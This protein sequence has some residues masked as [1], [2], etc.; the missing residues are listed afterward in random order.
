MTTDVSSPTVD[1]TS[2]TVRGA[3]RRDVE[4]YKGIPY[5][6][7]TGGAPPLGR[8]GAAAPPG[9]ARPGRPR[10]SG[11]PEPA[12]PWSGVRDALAYGPSCPQPPLTGLLSGEA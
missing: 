1:T 3:R 9:G 11:A 10:G 8:A 12:P 4:V 7:T 6:A 2:G 5:D